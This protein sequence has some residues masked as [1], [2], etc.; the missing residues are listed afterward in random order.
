MRKKLL[1][2]HQNLF[3]QAPF[4]YPEHRFHF[5][6]AGYGSGKTSSL[7]AA[8]EK[9]VFEL[10]GK[11]DREGHG[12]RIILGGINLGHLEK[13][14]LAFILEDLDNSSTPH[15]FDKKDKKLIVGN[16]T[17]LMVSLSEPEKIAGYDAAA[18]L[19]DEVDDLHGA[20]PDR[21]TFEAVRAL[22]ERARQRIRGFRSPFLMFAS[23]S[24]GQR[25]L[26]RVYNSFKKAGIGFTLVRGRTADNPHADPTL[27][28][29][30]YKM[31]SPAERAVYLEGMFIALAS[32]RVFGDFDWARN[33]VDIDMDLTVGE[34]ETVYWAQDFNQGYHRGCAAVLREGIIYIIKSYEFPDIRQA[35]KVLR[36]DFPHNKIIWIPD[37]TAKDQITQ[38]TKELHKYRIWWVTRGRNPNVEDT[39]FLVNKLLYSGRMICTKAARETAEALAGFMRDKNNQVPKGVGPQSYSHHADGPRWIAQFLAL[40]QRSLQDIRR[41]TIERHIRQELNDTAEQDAPVQDLGFG[42]S[43]INPDAFSG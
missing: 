40:T 39:V 17:T 33:Y 35:P 27:A 20:D 43:V 3:I 36:Y 2:L 18:I 7:S 32:G 6:V 9:T 34:N 19:A 11:K 21:T 29:S 1:L 41:I 26:Y 28:S 15:K 30:M 12:P 5:L 14:T 23:T 42:Y 24:Q 4:L 38:F 8:W 22:N 37:T 16:T 13:T 25:G 10:Q 31:F